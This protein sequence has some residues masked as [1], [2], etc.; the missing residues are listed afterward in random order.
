MQWQKIIFEGDSSSIIK[1]CKVKSPDKSLVG[2]YIHDIQQ[3]LLKYRNCRFEYIPRI[4]NSLA[5]ILATETLKNKKEIYL[6][7]SVP[8]SAEKQEERNRVREPD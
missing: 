1:K 7:G 3:L 6:V 4:A 2:A 5:H 8:E